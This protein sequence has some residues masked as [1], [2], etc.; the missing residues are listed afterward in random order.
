MLFLT[1]LKILLRRKETLFWVL[2][3]PLLLAT[4]E[5][6]AFGNFVNT[7]PIDTIPIGIIMTEE[8]APSDYLVKIGRAHV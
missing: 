4:A 8:Y 5:Y 1:R 7:T 3:F 6:L 2:I